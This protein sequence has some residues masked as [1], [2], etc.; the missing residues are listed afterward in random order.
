MPK[1]VAIMYMVVSFFVVGCS[2]ITYKENGIEFHRF[3]FGQI[4]TASQLKV[5]RDKEGHMTL[6]VS[7]LQ[8]DQAE[9]LSKVVEG[10]VK[11]AIQG[12]K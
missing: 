1:I 10:A 4:T 5:G 9:A 11:G 12:A 6:T 2:S 7:G 8:N 3:S